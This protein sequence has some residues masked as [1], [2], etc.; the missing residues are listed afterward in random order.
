MTGDLLRWIPCGRSGNGR[1]ASHHQW[2]AGHCAWAYSQP[3]PCKQPDCD[4]WRP[5]SA[6]TDA[7]F[8]FF[9]TIRTGLFC[10]TESVCPRQRS[11]PVTRPRVTRVPPRGFPGAMCVR[12]PG[13]NH[14]SARRIAD[15]RSRMCYIVTSKVTGLPGR[16]LGNRRSAMTEVYVW[17]GGEPRHE[18]K[19]TY[20]F[21]DR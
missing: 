13:V 11:G 7:S 9:M 2:A 16:G 10:S 4:P 14:P 21:F 18:F 15:W 3:N 20:L 8:L 19:Y 5:E 12:C 1:G 6:C 17:G